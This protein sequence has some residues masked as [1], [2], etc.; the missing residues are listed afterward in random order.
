M[1][2]KKIN[3]VSNE[4]TSLKKPQE[5]AKNSKYHSTKSSSKISEVMDE[6]RR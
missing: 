1:Y 2:S 4:I 3:I 6:K 5:V